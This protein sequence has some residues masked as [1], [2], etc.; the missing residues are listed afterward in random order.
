MVGKNA[1]IPD[2]PRYYYVLTTQMNTLCKNSCLQTM[3]QCSIYYFQL[4]DISPVTVIRVKMVVDVWNPSKSRRYYI[5]S[6]SQ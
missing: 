4:W 2:V 5:K 1:R 6:D 3:F